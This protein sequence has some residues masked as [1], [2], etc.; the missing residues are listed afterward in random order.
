MV[1]GSNGEK[2]HSFLIAFRTERSTQQ[3][4]GDPS[5]T[6]SGDDNWRKLENMSGLWGDSV[7]VTSHHWTYPPELQAY[8]FSHKGNCK[9]FSAC[10]HR[11]SCSLLVVT[12][13]WKR[14]CLGGSLHFMPGFCSWTHQYIFLSRQIK[15]RIV[16][17]YAYPMRGRMEI[18][19]F[20]H[21]MESRRVKPEEKSLSFLQTNTVQCPYSARLTHTTV[22]FSEI[23]WASFETFDSLK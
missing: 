20:V 7:L 4:D 14:E 22:T 15:V 18:F 2:W 5:I 3:T 1:W 19:L 6:F 23:L 9:H 10:M 11:S 16:P 12:Q 21:S 8:L 13:L 17:V